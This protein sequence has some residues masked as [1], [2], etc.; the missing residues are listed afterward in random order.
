VLP[1][2]RVGVDAVGT[3]GSHCENWGERRK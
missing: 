3:V 2:G 1:R